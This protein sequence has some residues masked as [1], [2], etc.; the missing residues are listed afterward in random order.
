MMI[1]LNLKIVRYF[2]LMLIFIST[3][4]AQKILS[5]DESISIALGESYSIK[6]AELNLTSSQK[7]LEALK[8][9]LMSSV[10]LEFDAPRYS[11]Q[12]SSQFNPS[13]GSEE[14]FKTGNTTVEGRLFI[15]QPLLFSNGTVSLVGSLFGRDQYSDFSGTNRD[16]FSNLSIRLNQ[17]LFVFNQQK[18]NLEKAEINLERA[19]RNYTRAEREIIFNVTSAFLKLYQAKQQMEITRER[20]KQNE[21]SFQTASNKFKAGLIAEVESLQLEVDLAASKNELLDTERNF[22]ELKNEFKLLI[23]LELAEQIDVTAQID[24][25]ELSVDTQSAIEAALKFRPDLLNAED[26]IKLNEMT[27]EEVDSRSTF[28]AEI[29]AN[30]GINKNDEK[31]KNVFNDFLDNR[32]VVMTLSIPVWDWGKNSTEVQAAEA[33][34]KNAHLFYE[35]LKQTIRKEIISSVNRINSAKSRVKVLSKS[36]EVAEKSYE[37]SLERFKAGTI[38]SFDLSQVQLRLVEAKQNSLNALIDYEL[39][40]AQLE[41]RTMVNYH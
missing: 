33:D 22:E 21:E 23:G 37:I 27:I 7:N 13:T 9:G 8:L 36:V 40:I 6:D 15:S 5:L 26:N 19:Q 11:R 39:A 35:N 4:A 17:P 30:Y 25:I 16:Y 2:L 28:K 18:A 38:T 12:L 14:F 10:R 29:S 3:S 41:R 32:S 31:F 1:N 20:V 34:F 24:F